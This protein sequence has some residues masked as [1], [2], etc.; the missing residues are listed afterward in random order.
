VYKKFLIIIT[1]WIQQWQTLEA[2]GQR[3]LVSYSSAL[4]WLALQWSALQ[5]LVL[6][7]LA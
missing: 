4:Q 1:G 2:L 6:Q 3:F 7:W 5:W